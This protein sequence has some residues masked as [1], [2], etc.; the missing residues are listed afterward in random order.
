MKGSPIWLP[1]LLFF[2]TDWISPGSGPERVLFES[3]LGPVTFDHSRHVEF[4]N[5]QCTKCHHQEEKKRQPCRRC[6]KKKAEIREGDPPPFYQVKMVLCR[7]CHLERNETGEKGK[8]P[9]HCEQCHDIKKIV[10]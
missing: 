4:L 5:R 9:I 2:L 1:F 7:G 6:H 3:P 8:A 10:K